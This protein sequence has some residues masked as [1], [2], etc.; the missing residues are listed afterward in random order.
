MADY[1]WYATKHREDLIARLKLIPDMA[2][3]DI[4]TLL[5]MAV[6][7]FLK[8]HEKGN[9]QFKLEEFSKPGFEASPS[10]MSPLNR[11]DVQKMSDKDLELFLKHS[12][13]KAE[14]FESELRHRR[15]KTLTYRIKEKP[16]SSDSGA[17]VEGRAPLPRD[18]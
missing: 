11:D 5:E 16:A 10:I 13:S 4:S 6:E 2:G 14:L 3:K 7:E 18:T 9:P 8:V 12:R 15:G 17:S 1:H